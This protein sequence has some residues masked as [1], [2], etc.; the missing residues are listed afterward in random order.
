LLPVFFIHRG[1]PLTAVEPA[2]FTVFDNKAPVSSGVK[3][4]R[5]SDLPLKLGILID[6]SNSQRDSWVYR[7]NMKAVKEL[8]NQLIR[9]DDDRVFF[10]LFSTTVQA[11]P[12]L[13]KDQLAGVSLSN[14]AG[15]GTSLYDAIALGC[16]ERMGKPNGQ[17]PER[18]ILILLSDGDD[19]QSRITREQ[20]LVDAVNASVV[21]FAISTNNAGRSS[22]DAVLAR[23][24]TA[25]GGIGYAGGDFR[26]VPKIFSHIQGQIESMYYLSYAPS[27][28]VAK[29]GIHRVEIKPV[30]G[31]KLEVR[32]LE[33][34]AR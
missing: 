20:A 34:Y 6:T 18:R 4:I 1:K 8:A 17:A 33:A 11:S 19:N 10:E 26:D 3:L 16:L 32:G 29:E 24:S 2:S 5:G 21:I 31:A 30:K 14:R 7:D 28:T 22:G 13:S 15:G 9:R 12:L 27:D 23:L 25:T